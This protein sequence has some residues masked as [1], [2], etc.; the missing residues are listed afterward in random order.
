MRSLPSVYGQP[1]S[2]AGKPMLPGIQRS[3]FTLAF[4]LIFYGMDFAFISRFDRQRQAS[5][6]GRSWDFTIMILVAA[7]VLV[8]Q[9]I[10]LPWLGLQISSRYGLI[11]Q[12]L[13]GCLAI[14][15]LV[16]HTWSRL[17]LRQFYAERVEVQAEHRLVDT[18]P[19]ALVRHPVITSFFAI[20]TGLFLVN[21]AIPTL[22]VL[23]YT[24]WDFSRAARQ[25]EKLL[26]ETLSEYP[27]YMERVPRFLP[28]PRR[29]A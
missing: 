17:H 3:L 9:P 10:W 21:P 8:V 4:I 7:A 26:S 23:V 11:P 16:L 1:V 5:G 25:E 28:R 12:I 29:R 19:Y 27:A 14:L 6:S 13:G 24:F 18:G 2:Q 20:T 22:I 15:G